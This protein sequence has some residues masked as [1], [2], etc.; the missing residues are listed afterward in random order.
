MKQIID[1]IKPYISEWVSLPLIF[2]SIILS[3]TLFFDLGSILPPESITILTPIQLAKLVV[4][5]SLLFLAM[6]FCYVLLYRTFSKRPRS[7]DYEHISPPG[8]YKH[9]ITGEYFCKK[10]LLKDKIAVPL[11]PSNTKEFHCRLCNETYKIDYNVLI[12]N[13]YLSIA[14]DNDPLFKNHDKAVKELIL[15]KE[16]GQPSG[17]GDG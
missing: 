4:T 12:C 3:G 6:S 15:N 16:N 10:C 14:Q 2:L 9:K 5:L 1:I 13:S 11:S 7:K 8:F 17:G